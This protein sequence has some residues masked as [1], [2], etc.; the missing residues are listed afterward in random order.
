[1]AFDTST[2]KQPSESINMDLERLN[3]GLCG[4]FWGTT[5]NAQSNIAGMTVI[6]CLLIASMAT[7]F[8]KGSD[9]Q[10]SYEIWKY[11]SPI[12]TGSLGFLFGHKHS[13]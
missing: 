8:S 4:K 1:M 11:I 10:Y 13:K 2:Q 6:I 7:Y 5:G 12:I 9:N 3:A